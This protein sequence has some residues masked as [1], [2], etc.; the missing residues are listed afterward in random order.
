MKISILGD[1]ISTF[2]GYNPE[3]YAVY[4]DSSTQARN[5]LHSV[6]DTWWYQVI[7]ELNGE[8]CVN[9]S[10]SGSRV[11]GKAFPSATSKERLHCLHASSQPDVILIYLGFNDFGYGV[12]IRNRFKLND[13][14]CFQDAYN[15]ML[16]TIKNRYQARIICGTLM[17][18]RMAGNDYWIFPEYYHGIAFEEYNETIRRVARRNRCDLADLGNQRYETLDGTHPTVNGHREIANAWLKCLR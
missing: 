2:E 8:L 3:G 5:N 13:L 17:R 10:Y 1:S 14:S 15:I 18:T 12:K 11:S 7:K 6:S 9:N 4:Y 16:K